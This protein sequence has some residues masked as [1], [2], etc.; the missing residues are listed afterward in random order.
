MDRRAE[1]RLARHHARDPSPGEGQMG[2]ARRR[3]LRK[4]ARPDARRGAGDAAARRRCQAHAR[5]PGKP[6]VL[7]R[8]PARQ[9]HRVA[10]LRSGPVCG[11]PYLARAAEEHSGPHMPW[12]WQA[13]RQSGRVLSDMTCHFVCDWAGAERPPDDDRH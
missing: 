6:G 12:F 13:Q 3:R 4:A 1:F 9:G 5:L 2:E 10:P 7:E 11:R 8:R